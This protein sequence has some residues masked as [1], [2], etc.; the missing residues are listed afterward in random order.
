MIQVS[1]QNRLRLFHSD[2]IETATNS[3]VPVL[4]EMLVWVDNSEFTDG[5]SARRRSKAAPLP[6]ACLRSHKPPEIVSEDL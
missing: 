2:S 6:I 5:L 1:L 3:G 4:K